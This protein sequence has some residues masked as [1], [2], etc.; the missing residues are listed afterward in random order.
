MIIGCP[1]CK[2]KFDI[3]DSLIPNKG[4]L[5]QCSSCGNKWFFKKKNEIK[6]KIQ[7]ISNKQ[8]IDE[9][10]KETEDLIAEAEKY[11]IVEKKT[12]KRKI[13]ILNIILILLINFIALIIVLD[14]FKIQINNIFP[15]FE[16]FL[17]NFYETLKDIYLFLID[18]IKQ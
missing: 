12:K 9:I 7:R 15:N 14:T 4:R 11:N 8:K 16:F 10:P 2:K 18:L 13:S 3:N 6:T 17:E 5:L 1:K